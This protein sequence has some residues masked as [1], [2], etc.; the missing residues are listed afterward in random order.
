MSRALAALLLVAGGATENGGAINIDTDGNVTITK[1]TFTGNTAAVN[2]GA[3]YFNDNATQGSAPTLIANFNRIVGNTAVS[4][5]GLYSGSAT[6]TV[7]IENNWWGCNAG[8]SAAPCDLVAGVNAA[9]FNPWLKLSLTANPTS[10]NTGGMS[11]L[12]ASFLTNSDNINVGASN[13]S[14]L[15]GVPVTFGATLGTISNADATIQSSGTAAATFRGEG[16]SSRMCR[17]ATRAWWTPSGSPSR[18]AGR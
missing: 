6:G 8:P 4:G 1:S 11:A 14:A 10:V 7:S 3:I 5:N 12:T 2:G 15:I 16:K 13:L 9:D 17:V 18:T